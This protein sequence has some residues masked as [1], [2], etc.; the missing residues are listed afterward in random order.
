MANSGTT[1]S[2]ATRSPRPMADSITVSI[3]SSG[4]EAAQRNL[5]TVKLLVEYGASSGGIQTEIRHSHFATMAGKTDVVNF[6]LVR[7]PGSS[8]EVNGYGKGPLHV[9][10]RS[11]LAN[12]DLVRVLVEERPEA[13]GHRRDNN[14]SPILSILYESQLT[15][16]PQR[17]RSIVLHRRTQE[18]HN[19]V[20]IHHCTRW[21]C[22][23]IWR[24]GNR[25][26]RDDLVPGHSL[27][28]LHRSKHQSSEKSV[29]S[30]RQERMTMS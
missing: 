16:P 7:K 18:S 26:G 17:T 21:R 23:G 2:L 24:T 29:R 14:T 10:D 25:A 12:V 8:T 30:A 11:L 28:V 9:A 27:A 4:K 22:G 19:H 20:R 13:M 5:E 15:L 3:E 6:R 1:N